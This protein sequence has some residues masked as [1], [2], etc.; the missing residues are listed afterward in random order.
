VFVFECKLGAARTAVFVFECKLG[1]ART[2]VFV[3]VFV[4]VVVVEIDLELSCE[5]GSIETVGF[6]GRGLKDGA[7][8][9]AAFESEY[10]REVGLKDNVAKPTE[11]AL[12]L[13]YGSEMRMAFVPLC[14]VNDG[15]RSATVLE[16]ELDIE[17]T[18]LYGSEAVGAALREPAL[19]TS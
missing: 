16:L 13:E 18:E 6:V 12:V 7:P 4:V 2:V 19:T 14:E 15:S 1:A 5:D 11:P 10:E 3:F 8:T 17:A 9:T